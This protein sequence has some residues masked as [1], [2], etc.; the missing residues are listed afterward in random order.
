MWSGEHSCEPVFVTGAVDGVGPRSWSRWDLWMMP[1][2][3]RGLLVPDPH[4]DALASLM[5]LHPV[6]FQYSSSRLWILGKTGIGA[7]QR[8]DT[9]VRQMWRDGNYTVS[10]CGIPQDLM[11][12]CRGNQHSVHSCPHRCAQCSGG[13]S[14]G[15]RLRVVQEHRRAATHQGAGAA[16][17]CAGR[18]PAANPAGMQDGS[19]VGVPGSPRAS[20]NQT[21]AGALTRP[22]CPLAGTWSTKGGAPLAAVRQGRSRPATASPTCAQAGGRAPSNAPKCVS[23]VGCGWSDW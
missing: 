6:S 22:R 12:L 13:L 2:R 21:T 23:P 1:R 10:I 17:Q 7:G 8:G 4:K 16:R 18:R 14:P 9:C 5:E 11:L 20:W 15:A 19:A 3:A